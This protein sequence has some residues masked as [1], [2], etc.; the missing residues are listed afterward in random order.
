MVINQNEDK[1]WNKIIMYCKIISSVNEIEI[2]SII[3]EQEIILYL[4]L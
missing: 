4:K 2:S 3:G 1:F